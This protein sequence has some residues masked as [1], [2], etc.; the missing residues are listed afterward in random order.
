M[1]PAPLPC[2][3]DIYLTEHYQLSSTLD[4]SNSDSNRSSY[5]SIFNL[6][7]HLFWTVLDPWG[8]Q[9]PPMDILQYD[10]KPLPAFLVLDQ[11]WYCVTLLF[12][13]RSNHTAS[14]NRNLLQP[15]RSQTEQQNTDNLPIRVHS[16]EWL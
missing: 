16:T 2:F 5:I 4:L 12:S 11:S 13:L 9:V 10:T 15:P 14:K 7:W 8:L 3:L 1:E 6:C